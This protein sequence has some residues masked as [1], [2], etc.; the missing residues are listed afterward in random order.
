M[1]NLAEYLHLKSEIERL[2]REIVRRDKTIHRLRK[3]SGI[4]ARIPKR[5]VIEL[6]EQGFSTKQITEKLGVHRSTVQRARQIKKAA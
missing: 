6:V 4:K 5:D 3:A 2:K 1:N